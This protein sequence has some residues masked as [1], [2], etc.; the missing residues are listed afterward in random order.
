MPTSRRL[1][2]RQKIHE[3]AAANP[4]AQKKRG[5]SRGVH[6]PLVCHRLAGLAGGSGRLAGRLKRCR[7]SERRKSAPAA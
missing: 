4:G 5:D 2:E 7:G 1:L 6:C 3:H